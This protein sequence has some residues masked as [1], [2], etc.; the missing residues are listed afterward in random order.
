MRRVIL[1]LIATSFIG[2]CGPSV[3]FF[4]MNDPP[5]YILAGEIEVFSEK[6][7][8]RYVEIGMIKV[9][10]RSKLA[11]SPEKM[12]KLLKA[13][14]MEAGADAVIIAGLSAETKVYGSVHKGTGYVGSTSKDVLTAIAIAWK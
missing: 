3:K 2:G 9:K 4:P 1:V 14:A 11:S 8:R 7:D 13:R 12:M 5:D 10:A 6:P